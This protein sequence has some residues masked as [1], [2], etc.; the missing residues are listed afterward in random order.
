MNKKVDKFIAEKI[1]KDPCF[2]ARYSWTVQKADIAKKIIKYRLQHNLS[3]THLAEKLGVTQQYISKIEEGNFSN[4]ATVEKI[5]FRMG[6]GIKLEI[7]Y[8]HRRY[9]EQPATA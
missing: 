8:L 4:L 6:Y 3:Q 1:Q 9:S 2:K 5:L 7:V